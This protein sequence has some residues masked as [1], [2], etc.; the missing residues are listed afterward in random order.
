MHAN[1]SEICARVTSQVLFEVNM[2][3]KLINY[4]RNNFAERFSH[5]V[6]PV[7]QSFLRSHTMYVTPSL[8]C[9]VLIQHYFHFVQYHSLFIL[10]KAEPW[11]LIC[12]SHGINVHFS[13][14]ENE[15][16]LKIISCYFL[17]NDNF[18]RSQ[19]HWS[20]IVGSIVVAAKFLISL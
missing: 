17:I 8:V 2:R 4:L 6:Q 7:C 14:F 20:I 10:F 11:T 18:V 3:L 15:T 13:I 1:D 19:K 9:A 5:H 16:F 12:K